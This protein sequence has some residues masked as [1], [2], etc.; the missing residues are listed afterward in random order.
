MPQLDFFSFKE[1]IIYT[2]IAFT[3]LYYIVSKVLIPHITSQELF[4]QKLENLYIEEG[5][6]NNNSVQPKQIEI[7][8]RFLKIVLTD[9]KRN[10]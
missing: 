2:L 7:F 1:Q 4:L 10:K 9:I 5:N 3:I 6:T 8:S